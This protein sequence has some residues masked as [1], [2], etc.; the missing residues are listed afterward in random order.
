MDDVFRAL[1]DPTRRRLLD[2]LR[3]ENGQT[4]GRLCGSLDMTRQ[5]VTQ[6]LAVL[7]QANL[8]STV[9]RGREKWHYLNPVPIHD[10]RQ[11]WIAPFEEPRM[12][13]LDA[14]RRQAEEPSMKP[15]F[16]YVTYIHAT[17]ARVWEALID[18]DL[19]GRYWGHSN[20]SDWRPGSPWE[21]RRTDGSG[22]ADAGGVVLEVDPPTRLV[23]T[24][25]DAGSTAGPDASTVTFLIE[26][27]HDIVRLTVTQVN[28]RSDDDL[29]AVSLGWPAVMANLKSLLETGHVLPQ[30]PWEVP[31][32]EPAP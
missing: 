18:A 4:L 28:L 1:A 20:V 19:T 17:P 30:A 27:H 9:R 7:E 13:T 2:S 21:H 3:R 29:A 16:V 32:S 24:F 15:E 8:I 5:S 11:R 10:M 25:G 23:M 22:I 6:H 14:I 12:R 26:P 31:V